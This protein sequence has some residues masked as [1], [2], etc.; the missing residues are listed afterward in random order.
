MDPVQILQQLV[1]HR[2]LVCRRFH[3]RFGGLRGLLGCRLG[4]FGGFTFG[5]ARFPFLR[6]FLSYFLQ[7]GFGFGLFRSGFL[8][9]GF[10]LGFGFGIGLA[11]GF[12]CG[13][14][15]RFRLRPGLGFGIDLRFFGRLR[16]GFFFDFGLGRSGFLRSRGRLS[17]GLLFR[18]R[19]DLRGGLGCRWRFFLG[20]CRFLDLFFRDRQVRLRLKGQQIQLYLRQQLFNRRNFCG[21]AAFID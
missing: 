3:C 16:L 6:P 11:F 5:H 13:L 18:Q 4:G 10:R 21:H 2:F 14:R 15:F 17:R 12:F 8:S 7:F 1:H 20:G 9:L 19:D